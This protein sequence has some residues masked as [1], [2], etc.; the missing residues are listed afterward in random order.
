M[1]GDI[2][3]KEHCALILGGGLNGY[4]TARELAECGVKNIILTDEKKD[5]AFFS[6]K[7]LRTYIREA[8]A[9]NI[10]ELILNLQKEFDCVVVY[11]VSD[12]FLTTLDEVYDKLN[13]KR[14]ILLNSDTLHRYYDKS[15]QY[16]F[17]A[18][19]DIAYPKTLVLT[20][21][22]S[23]TPD[24]LQYPLL[25]KPNSCDKNNYGKVFK[26]LIVETPDELN[27]KRK[28]L[29]KYLSSGIACRE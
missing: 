16:A 19:N 26:T 4:C 28:E 8:T 27:Q 13:D 3:K 17:C 12:I 25:I 18:D 29:E 6:N 20:E 7:L 1:A 2:A 24:S 15:A 23:S 14:G 22:F 5:Y 11:P 10:L 21:Y 9:E